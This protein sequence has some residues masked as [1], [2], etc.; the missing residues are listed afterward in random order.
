M[1]RMMYIVRT[2]DFLLFEAQIW[3]NVL[4]LVYSLEF[5]PITVNFF[6]YMNKYVGLNTDAGRICPYIHTNT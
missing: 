2:V 1:K 5:N 6:S 4:D 3:H